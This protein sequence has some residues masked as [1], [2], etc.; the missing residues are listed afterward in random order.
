M[1]FTAIVSG[2]Y[3]GEAKMCKNVLKLRTLDGFYGLNYGKTV[4]DR[5]VHAASRLTS[6]EFSFDP[7][8]IYRDGPRG[9]G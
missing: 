5:W 9:V 1:T 4:E 2:A 6:I 3:P 7:C 8:N